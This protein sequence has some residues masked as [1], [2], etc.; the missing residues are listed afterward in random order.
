MSGPLCIDCV[1]YVKPGLWKRFRQ[2]QFADRCDHPRCRDDV[3]GEPLP[4]VTM[5][6]GPCE[7]GCLFKRWNS[8]E[9]E[10]DQR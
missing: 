1:Y 6:L 7:N 3:N 10:N 5:R 8:P 2:E 9:A 4:C